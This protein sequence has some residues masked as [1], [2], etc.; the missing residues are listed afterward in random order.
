MCEWLKG[1]CGSQIII[2]DKGMQCLLKNKG[3]QII[4]QC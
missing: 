2:G 1:Q 4:V 3:F